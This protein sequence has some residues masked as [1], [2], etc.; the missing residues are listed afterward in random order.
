LITNVINREKFEIKLDLS[1][2]SA[3]ASQGLIKFVKCPKIINY[4]P[5]EE[6][7]EIYSELIEKHKDIVVDFD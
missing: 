4:K 7:Y 3:Y 5:L 2:Y 1:G 6:Y